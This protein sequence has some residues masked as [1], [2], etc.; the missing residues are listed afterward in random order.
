MT[1]ST[2]RPVIRSGSTLAEMMV[3][4]VSASA[5]MVGTA[6]AIFVAV[7]GTDTSNT[8]T[9]A[10]I[11]GSVALNDVLSELEFALSFSEQ[12]ATAITFT[13]PDRDGDS[14]PETIRYA[15]SGTPGD[16][17]TRQY[18]GGT[19]ANVAVNVH[20]FQHDL[21]PLMP[22]LLS[23]ADMEAGVANWE[24]IPGASILIQSSPVHS[25]SGAL[26]AWQGG[27]S[28]NAGA[29]QN[30]TSQLVNGTRYKISAW[31]RKF[32]NQA[33]YDA[34]LQLRIN[35]SGGGEQLFAT[36]PIVTNNSNYLL[37][38]GTVTPIWSGTLLSAHWEASGVSNIKDLY[39]DDAALRVR[40]A[41]D[42][43]VNISMQ[44]G[45]ESQSLVQSGVVLL[46]SPL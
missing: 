22:N 26:E 31:L 10:T 3:A 28:D 8:P 37:A 39:I 7:Q 25:G 4:L 42:Q 34:K 36:D 21:P 29:R 20:V 35:S 43:I 45:A 14:N 12:S 33:P 19:A 17:L 18:N 9:S 46:N 11:D 24:A 6:S 38:S 27:P 15:W 30:V 41:V 1:R 5:L 44:V 16:P 23:N 40:P 32:T 13:V 2:N